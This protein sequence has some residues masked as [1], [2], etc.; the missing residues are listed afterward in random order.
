M[1]QSS[2]RV[3]RL[4][5]TLTLEIQRPEARNALNAVVLNELMAG[6]DE[7]E[8]DPAIAV[9]V[10]T[11]SGEVFSAGGDLKEAERLA[12]EPYLCYE[13]DGHYT[14]LLRRLRE[15][16][17]PTLAAVDGPALGG[18]LG[19]VAACDLAIAS[20]RAVFGTPEVRVGTF[21]L[22]VMAPLLSVLGPRAA[23]ELFLT[24]GTLT[25]DEARALGLVNRV[26]PHAR[27]AEEVAGYAASLEGN[28]PVAVRLG[29]EAF[30]TVPGMRYEQALEYLKSMRTVLA[31]TADAKEGRRAF[32][33]KRTPRWIGR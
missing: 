15:V 16:S 10:V 9:V 26:V 30:Y 27:F 14:R 29:K 11:G 6:L 4:N 2:V 19:L 13:A 25:A 5:G 1:T 20:D 28:S 32:L 12:N 21:P 18:G 33:E 8:T 24:G 23:M 31:E 3:H 17:K 7:A 22:M